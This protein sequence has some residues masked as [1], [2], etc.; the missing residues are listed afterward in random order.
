MRLTKRV[1][2]ILYAGDV[3]RIGEFVCPPHEPR[4]REINTIECGELAVFP[5]TSVVIQHHGR[6][7]ALVNRN[8]VVFYNRGQLYR[9]WLHDP[10]GERSVFV[11]VAPRLLRS[12]SGRAEFHFHLGP[13]SAHAFLAQHALVRYLLTTG[14]PDPLYVEETTVNAVA[15]VIEGAQA[16]ARLRSPSREETRAAQHELVEAAKALLTEHVVERTPLTTIARELYTSEF[17]LARIFR[18][19][20]GFSLHGYRKQLRLR[21]ALDYLAD[22]AELSGIAH[23]LGFASHSHFTD[24]FRRA[25]GIAPS[26]IRETLG[27]RG[28]RKLR[29]ALDL[30][31]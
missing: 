21:L 10:A 12:I 24:S 16:L 2:K 29:S 31:L 18:R 1:K 5:R 23:Q 27:H 9:R 20:T 15:D 7:A 14:S 11:L 19:A 30:S 26:A 22:G 28:V 6:D 13:A 4:W 8:H 25:F 3:V 17:H